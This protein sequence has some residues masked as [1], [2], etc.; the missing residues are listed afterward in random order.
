MANTS[1]RRDFLRASAVATTAASY[2]RILGANDRVR[3]GIS[4]PAAAD[5]T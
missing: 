2:G 1:S 4:E 5:N 3:L